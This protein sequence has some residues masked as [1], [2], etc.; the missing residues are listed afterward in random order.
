MSDVDHDRRSDRPGTSASIA[1]SDKKNLDGQSDVED[2]KTVGDFGG[3]VSSAKKEGELVGVD[4]EGPEGDGE[5]E[6][7]MVYPS[8]LKLALLTL[9]L[10]LVLFVV[11]TFI[12]IIDGKSL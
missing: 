10:C 2:E 9:G 11:R 7:V 6:D 4:G 12:S 1:K 8:G 5:S 3:D